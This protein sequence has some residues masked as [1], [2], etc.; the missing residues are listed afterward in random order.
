M[1][2]YDRIRK[3]QS[4]ELLPA[5]T[6]YSYID[7]ALLG[8]FYPQHAVAIGARP[9]VGKSWLAQ[10]IMANVMNAKLNPQANDYVWLRCEFEMNPEDLILRSLSRKMNEDIEDILLKEMNENELKIMQDCLKSE[11]S[12][13][14]TYIPK[15]VTVEEFQ[16]FLSNEYMPVNKDKKMV[17]VSIDHTAL[18]QGTGD[19]KRNIDSLINMCNIAKRTYPNIFFL[20]ISQLNRD[21]EGRRDPKDQMPRQSDFYQSDTLGQLCT[22]MIALN[23]P[24]RYGYS[25]Y[26]SFPQNWYPYLERFKSDSGRSFRVDGLLFHHIVK[27]RQRSLEEIDTIHVDIM[28]GYERYY[29]NGGVVRQERPGGSDAPEGSGR[30]KPEPVPLPPPEIPLE[31]QEIKPDMDF[32]KEHNETPF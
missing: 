16:D 12:A 7:K 15:P 27:V 1:D 11:N 30:P 22:A 2:A 3:Y 24:K 21:I 8:G 6:G 20:I 19:A 29:P 13:R 26:M 9:G 23:I 32:Y 25:S 10:R 14:I 4:G 17:F 31:R 28:K 5:R 18:I